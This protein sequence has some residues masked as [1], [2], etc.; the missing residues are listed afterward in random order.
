MET[1]ELIFTDDKNAA[2]VSVIV[3]VYNTENYLGECLK[4][5]IGQTYCNI[6]IIAVNDGATDDSLAVLKCFA[7][8]DA[9]IKIIDKENGGLSSA[10][11]EGLKAANGKYVMFLDS[12]DFFE[13]NAIEQACKKMEED[14]LDVCM[15]SHYLLRGNEKTERKVAFHKSF[16]GRK[17]IREEVIPEFIGQKN[18]DKNEV[19]AFVTPQIFKRDLIGEQRFLSEREYYMED[20]LFDLNYY[21]KAERFGVS[22]MPLY[23]YRIVPG[24][25]TNSYRKNLFEKFSKLFDYVSDYMDANGYE[26]EKDRLLRRAFNL[27]KAAVL[28]IKSA[29]E[30]STRDKKKSIKEIAEN[31]YIKSAVKKLRFSGI[32]NKAYSF[33]LKIKAAGVILKFC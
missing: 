28:N 7:Q 9:R 22:D 30:M 17:E 18:D 33:L 11:N 2:K 4:S 23:S 8:K 1:G 10:R 15:F 5:I 29:P 14:K 16:Y 32:K 31:K 27:S 19:F 25:L 20:L 6:E 21:L 24:S 3:P 26:N 13:P 12:D